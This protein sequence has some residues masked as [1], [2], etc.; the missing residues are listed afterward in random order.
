MMDMEAL[1]LERPLR[2]VL[3]ED[4]ALFLEA[5]RQVRAGG[6][7]VIWLDESLDAET[8]AALAPLAR[9]TPETA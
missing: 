2:D 9:A 7:A 8:Q 3:P 1:V 5:V 6:G 4:R